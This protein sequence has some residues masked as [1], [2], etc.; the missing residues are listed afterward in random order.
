[1]LSPFILNAGSV[2]ALPLT[3]NEF[4][5]CGNHN[6]MAATKVQSVV[7]ERVL[8][9]RCT[10]STVEKIPLN[11]C[12]GRILARAIISDVNV[13]A[14]IRASMDG[15]ALRGEETFDSSQSNPAIFRVVGEV[16]AG[17]EFKDTVGPGEAIRIMTGAPLPAGTNAVLMAEHAHDFGSAIEAYA[18]VLPGKNAGHVGED[19]GLGNEVLPAGRCLRPQDVGL[20]ASIGTDSVQVRRKPLVTLLITGNELLKP[21]AKPHGSMIVDSN[22]LMLQALV[23]RDGGVVDQTIYLPD[24]KARIRQALLSAPGDVLLVTGGTSVGVEDHAPLL[25]AE[26]GELLVH[27][28]AMR[29]GAPTGFGWVAERPVFLLP[30]N[31]VACLA[32]YDFFAGLAIRRLGGR[33]DHWPYRQIH[34]QLLER[35]TSQ[36]GRLDY[37]RVRMESGKAVLIA[38]AAASA[39]STTTRADGFVIVPDDTDEFG[40][41]D[42][43]S[44]W[45]YD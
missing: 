10:H 3:R 29:P 35:I 36:L 8:V 43:V 38:T 40:P 22:A 27:G 34:M 15:Y 45:L 6:R 23:Q 37:A 44:V 9:P 31:P 26:L 11:N 41:G 18:E 21:G 4:H 42:L 19:I 30:G 16:T 39:L 17:S 7:S 32:A 13:P 25:V 1:M 12:I 14:F 2:S 5:A 33:A 28:V 20:L 24:D